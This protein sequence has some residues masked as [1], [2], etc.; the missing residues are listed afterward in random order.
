MHYLLFIFT[1]PKLPF[2]SLSATITRVAKKSKF[3]G[4]PWGF[5]MDFLGNQNEDEFSRKSNGGWIFLGIKRGF[6]LLPSSSPPF[7]F[8]E[9]SSSFFE[10]IHA[11]PLGITKKI[12]F[13]FA[14]VFSRWVS[15]LHSISRK[16][17]LV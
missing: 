6:F 15:I 11:K 13:F 9:N 7:D 1:F 8:R 4:Y 17:I 3:F 2:I 14:P 12:D 10:K 5:C 16:F